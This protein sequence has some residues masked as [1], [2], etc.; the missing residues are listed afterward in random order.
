M[1]ISIF[2]SKGSGCSGRV[3]TN[4]GASISKRYG[5]GF[6]NDLTQP[7]VIQHGNVDP[8]YLS[9]STLNPST[10]SESVAY[11]VPN[12]LPTSVN[13]NINT[14]SDYSKDTATR[15]M[16]VQP[17]I[18]PIMEIV[19]CRVMEVWVLMVVFT[20]LMAIH[21]GYSGLSMT[22]GISAGRITLLWGWDQCMA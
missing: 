16:E 10:A 21:S 8:E 17:F 11:F 7:I 4:T 5:G 20:H 14:N 22:M 9:Q 13:Q 12:Y 1:M 18:I 3:K 19:A 2:R 6:E 15:L